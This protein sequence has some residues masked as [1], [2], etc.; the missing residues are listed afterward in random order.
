MDGCPGLLFGS[1]FSMEDD[2]KAIYNPVTVKMLSHF[3]AA[4]KIT[5]N[6]N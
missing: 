2:C 1:F 4:L 6:K 5:E 3:K